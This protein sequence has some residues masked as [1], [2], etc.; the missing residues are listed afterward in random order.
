MDTNISPPHLR[1]SL[2]YL[3]V[4]FLLSITFSAYA[5][6]ETLRSPARA[7]AGYQGE[8]FCPVPMAELAF[9][10]FYSELANLPN[11]RLRFEKVRI[12]VHE[13][14]LVTPYVYRM[15]ELFENEN[16][17]YDLLRLTF[18]Y[19]ADPENFVRL[20]PYLEGQVYRDAFERFLRERVQLQRVDVDG[21][22]Q[23]LSEQELDKALAI[24][25][26]LNSDQSILLVAE[27]LIRRNN[28]R[29]EQIRP[30]LEL[31]R[32]GS[33]Q[34]KLAEAAYPYVYDPENYFL[35]YD[36]LGRSDRRKIVRMIGDHPRPQEEGYTSA[37]E[38]GC[39]Y[40]AT[41]VE[42]ESHLETI[43]RQRDAEQQLR[44]AQQLFRTNCFNVQDLR[45]VMRLLSSDYERLQLAKVAADSV[46]D[47][48]NIYMVNAEFSRANSIDALHQFLVGED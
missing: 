19:S 34:Y 46:L 37:R 27:E 10:G 33:Y 26:E 8:S 17:E 16:Y 32:L 39:T 35:V 15:L 45:A 23:L 31:I 44:L 24:L 22:R 43:R 48:W 28:L 9:E 14:C 40:E 4:L 25:Q 42:I 36:A 20:L 7:M 3:G 47:P 38:L 2:P 11:D 1:F 12:E 6:P 29:S 41:D 13:L 5:Q 21:Q 18:Y 30:I